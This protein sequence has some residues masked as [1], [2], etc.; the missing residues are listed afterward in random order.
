[1]FP[2]VVRVISVLFHAAIV[3]ERRTKRLPPSTL[4]SIWSIKKFDNLAFEDLPLICSYNAE[5][6]KS[7]K[8]L[9]K[10]N[11]LSSDEDAFT[12]F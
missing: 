9:F 12:C 5:R 8:V 3:G 11:S 1:M 10:V 6:H 2:V 7:I 4:L